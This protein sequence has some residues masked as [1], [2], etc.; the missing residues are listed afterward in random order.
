[1][2]C[3]YMYSIILNDLVLYHSQP[4]RH[5]L[6]LALY[7]FTGND[8]STVD[9]Y[10]V[11]HWCYTAYDKTMYMA[12]SMFRKAVDI[13]ADCLKLFMGSSNDL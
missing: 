1:M 3:R 9:L 7:S 12:I 5:T 11:C 13:F 4:H 2:Y 6:Y 8:S 10:C